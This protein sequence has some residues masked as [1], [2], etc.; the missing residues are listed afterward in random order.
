MALTIRTDAK[1]LANGDQRVTARAR[2][3]QVTQDFDPTRPTKSHMSAAGAL[4]NR[5]LDREQQAKIHHPTGRSLVRIAV[6]EPGHR[7]I[8]IDV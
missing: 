5:L 8:V 3:K 2:G 6:T 1:T 7:V 4:A